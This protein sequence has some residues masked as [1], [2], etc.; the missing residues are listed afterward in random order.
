MNSVMDYSGS[1]INQEMDDQGSVLPGYFPYLSLMFKITVTT[2]ILLLSGWVVYTIKMTKSL[3]KPHN[4]FVANLLVSD[5]IS[6]LF[7]CVVSYH[8]SQ[9]SVRS[10]I[11][12][13]LFCC[14]PPF[15]LI[16]HQKHLNVDNST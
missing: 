16:Q 10:R 1:E 3:H 9:F 5:M 4:I 6:A 12:P 8:D 15:V 13:G 2:V 11:F 7:V 14:L